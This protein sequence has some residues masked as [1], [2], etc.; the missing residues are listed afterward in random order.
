MGSP[1]LLMIGACQPARAGSFSRG[2]STIGKPKRPAFIEED[3]DTR[4]EMAETQ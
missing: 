2:F 3:I 4:I 1:A